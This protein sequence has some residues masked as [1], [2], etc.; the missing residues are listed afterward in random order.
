MAS[1]DVT[2]KFKADASEFEKGA[3]AVSG[4]L[5]KI[6]KNIKDSGVSKL[7]TSVKGLVGSIGAATIAAKA[8]LKVIK[9]TA[10]AYRTQIKAEKQ[11]E[12]ASKNNPLISEKGIRNLKDYAGQLQKISTM[13]DEQLLPMM[14]QLV[15]LGRSE[16]EVQKI[17]NAALD[18][19]A[20]G[21][22][23]MEQAVKALNGTLN[24]NVGV[25]GRQIPGL[26]SLT[27]EQLKNGDAIKIVQDKFK[28]LSKEVTEQ[29]GSVEQLKN[30]FGDLKEEIGA[31][32]EKPMA[33]MRKFFTEMIGGWTK[34]AKAK[35]L[36][37]EGRSAVDSGKGTSV[38]Y[39][40]V[41]A[42]EYKKLEQLKRQQE[43]AYASL[44]N[45]DNMPA[46]YRQNVSKATLQTG[47]KNI[48]DQI[49]AEEAYILK[50][51]KEVAIQKQVEEQ[52]KANLEVVQEEVEVKKELAE[53]TEEVADAT[54][55]EGNSYGDLASKLGTYI[56]AIDELRNSASQFAS[57][58]QDSFSEQT[59]K[60]LANLSEQYTNGLVDYE[61]YCKEK[62][63]L[64]KKA[65]Q[66]EY[67]IKMWEWSASLAMATA[68]IAQ[69]VAA[70]LSK[71]PPAS[72]VLAAL[73]A[74]SGAL[75]LATLTANKPKP[76]AFQS[77]GIVPGNSYTGDK[78]SARVNSGEMI[79]NS[80]QQAQ[81]WKLANGGMGGGINMPVTI[82]NT[83]SDKVS[84]NATMSKNGLIITVN[85]I[86]NSQ[87]QKGV[88]T[89]S[90]NIANA[91]AE[92]VKYL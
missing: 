70:A 91:R 69:G 55:D 31:T 37:N 23:S 64:S 34:A 80:A 25:L 2:I 71:E 32:F 60:D 44:K 78:V 8:A 68:N 18:L 45:Y 87:M 79:L 42:G 74:S 33:K 50:L 56:S 92:G 72:Y 16:A 6:S 47:Y 82:N 5:N 51:Q 73:T 54:A 28:G 46:Q 27:A 19:S 7:T 17:M 40:D 61:T 29:T 15:A 65:A 58:I 48:A 39:E 20:S 88:Y 22:M 36:Y 77:G 4:E 30:S 14:S 52:A 43:T 86:V 89:G 9:D 84:A 3:K 41:L 13:G 24:G 63:K 90:M 49:A 62:T 75:Q 59:Q 11:L 38:Q 53:V 81:L 21:M 12:I 10:E 85:D 76:P 67:K 1:K 35:R 57:V 26:K 66:D 83:A